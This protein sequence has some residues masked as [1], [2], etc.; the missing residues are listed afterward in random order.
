MT[1]IS[2]LLTKGSQQHLRFSARSDALWFFGIPTSSSARRMYVSR[3]H[4][5]NTA[6]GVLQSTYVPSISQKTVLPMRGGRVNSVL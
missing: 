2:L 3:K 5:S 6:S 1:S 4:W